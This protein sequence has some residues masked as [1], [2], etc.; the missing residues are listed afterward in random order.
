MKRL[1]MVLLIFAWTSP[2][3]S[4]DVFR[5]EIGKKN[6]KSSRDELEQR[7]LD[8]ERAVWQLQQRVFSLESTQVEAVPD[9]SWLCTIKA[10]GEIYT[11]TG[12]SESTATVN[13]IEQCKAE[14]DGSSFFCKKP[15]CK[16]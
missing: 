12:T 7:V 15:S 14:N 16:K 13:A 3:W 5:I 10:M 8:L 11:G 6:R 4:E 2:A 9:E 1:F